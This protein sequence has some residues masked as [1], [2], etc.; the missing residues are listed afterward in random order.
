MMA[1]PLARFAAAAIGW[2][3]LVFAA[4]HAVAA[5]KIDPVADA[6]AFRKFFTDKFPKVKLGI[7]STGRIR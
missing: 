7:S 6:T 5:D 3:V 4:P 1:R 2:A